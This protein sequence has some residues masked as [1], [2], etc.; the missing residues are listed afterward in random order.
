MKARLVA[1]LAPMLVAAVL[2]ATAAASDWSIGDLFTRGVKG[3]GTL[4]E[5]EFA[6]GDFDRLEFGGALDVQV[7]IGSPA[8]VTARVDDNLAE[9]LVVEVRGRT[10]VLETE[11]K[12]RPS[13][14]IRFTIVAPALA[15]VEAS[16]ASTLELAGY[17]GLALELSVS[18]ASEAR[19]SGRVDEL[20]VH[21]SGASEADLED[22][23]AAHVIASASGASELVLN[24]TASL[25]ADASGASD[26]RF[27][28][29]P[30]ERDLAATGASEI[31][32][33]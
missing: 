22:L 17:D 16:G 1:L 31:E 21:A 30:A 15:A 2:P 18:G 10:L 14:G 24:A 29:D 11:R 13:E 27:L 7:R 23:V 19:V 3:S 26:I 32:P 28:G 8:S 9:L 20:E 5:R 6:V 25:D 33:R 4:V 12:I